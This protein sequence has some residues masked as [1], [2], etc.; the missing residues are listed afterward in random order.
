[1]LRIM[2]EQVNFFVVAKLKY[3]HS[4]KLPW[5]YTVVCCGPELQ[6]DAATV[7]KYKSRK[8]NVVSSYVASY[9]YYIP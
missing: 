2:A 6:N 7:A 1:M 3:L 5:A 9:S 8:D 4:V